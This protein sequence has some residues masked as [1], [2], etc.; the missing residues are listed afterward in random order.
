MFQDLKAHPALASLQP[1]D[2][3]TVE[4]SRELRP[5]VPTDY[6]EFLSVVGAGELG[7][8]RFTLYTGLIEPDDIYGEIPEGLEDIVLFGDDM[9][10][11]CAGY[12]TNTWKVVEIDPTN[13]TADV[14]AD[15]FELFIRER[16]AP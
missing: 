2:K 1:C 6:L 7:N 9:Q 16:V 8:G 14:I 10:G 11:Y 13:M 15:S 12:D 5:G 3:G 4:G